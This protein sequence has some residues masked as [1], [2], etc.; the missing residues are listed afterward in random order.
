MTATSMGEAEPGVDDRVWHPTG[1]P[2][3]LPHGA[4]GA[5]LPEAP[6]SHAES[7]PRIAAWSGYAR[8]TGRHT[9]PAR[10]IIRGRQSSE[11]ASQPPAR[12]SRADTEPATMAMIIS[13]LYLP[14]SADSIQH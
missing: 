4:P 12:T 13:T 7:C 9:A 5:E 2:E 6:G 8:P 14:E 1:L 3:G 11:T 10:K